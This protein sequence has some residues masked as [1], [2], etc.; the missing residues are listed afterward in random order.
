MK[1]PTTVTGIIVVVSR[2]NLTDYIGFS[3]GL[4]GTSMAK[5]SRH[6]RWKWLSG[7]GHISLT[8]HQR[9]H[10]AFWWLS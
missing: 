5:E 10:K 9:L 8:Y 4:F 1:Q 3:S 2:C 7:Y 6:Y